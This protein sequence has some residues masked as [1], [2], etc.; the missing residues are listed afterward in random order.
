MHL[1]SLCFTLLPRGTASRRFSLYL[2]RRLS[3]I[4]Y[5][6]MLCVDFWMI[7]RRSL[8]I[9]TRVRIPSRSHYSSIL[10][11]RLVPSGAEISRVQT[12][13]IDRTGVDAQHLHAH[14]HAC[15]GV[16][17]VPDR[18]SDGVLAAVVQ[19]ARRHRELDL[20]SD[21]REELACR[22]RKITSANRTTPAYSE[23]S[24]DN[25]GPR[26]R[27]G[28]HCKRLTKHITIDI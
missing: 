14:T 1:R 21:V 20:V 12:S 19:N 23:T 9:C 6:S 8:P 27:E 16:V 22:E 15:L 25:A 10:Q 17:L 13:R 4:G 28:Q 2:S 5:T 11:P 3:N 18:Q 24:C 26:G 7:T